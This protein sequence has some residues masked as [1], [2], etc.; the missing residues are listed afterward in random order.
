MKKLIVI[1]LAVCMLAALAACG[2]GS[3]S[4]STAQ[5]AVST[6]ANSTA[7]ADQGTTAASSAD[8]TII[9]DTTS[10]GKIDATDLF[11][12]RDLKQTADLSD[13]TAY[14]VSD[15]QNIS[16]TSAGVYVLTGTAQN[17]TVTVDAASDD[18]VQLVLGGVSITNSSTP[19]IYVKS[20]DKV[21]VTT[22][23][24]TENTLS[25]TGAFTAD[26]NTN[27]DAVIFSKDDL[28]LNG[29]GTLNISSTDNGI[30]GKDDIKITGGTINITCTSDA[31]EAHDSIRIADGVI[32]V[33]TKK[34][35]LHAENDEDDSVGYIYIC[36]G[37]FDIT[38]SSDGIQ[39]ATV[40]Q[41]DGG[42]FDITGSEGIEAT[43]V[44]IN[45]GDITI[46]A[47]DDGINASSK[48]SA[49]TPTVEINGGNILI[50]MGAGDTDGVDA[51]GNL[52]INGGT[53]S[54]NA[55]S[56]FDYDGV[57]EHNGGTIIVNGVETDEITNQF[58]GGMGGGQPG[59]I[60]G[61]GGGRPGW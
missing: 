51:N 21:F 16:I 17:V 3:S 41:I 5:S 8:V 52:Y 1:L 9:A 42:T 32:T 33:N 49:Y 15:G 45:G 25:V 24:G 36:G 60:G 6:A 54:V 34:D 35:A 50:N 19:A 14:T 46:A 23:A 7:S 2:S 47:S 18:K 31:I 27:T 44:Q 28:V 56:P 53:I 61:P 20:A 39:G 58:G 48:S 4:D 12:D 57:A 13:A 11:S 30:S 37:T 26:G 10:N 29:L 40:V 38:A 59:G 22:A 55:N 43:Y